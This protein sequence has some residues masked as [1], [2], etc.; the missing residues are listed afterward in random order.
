VARVRVLD[1][2][3]VN[4][5]AAGEVVERP[6]SVVKEL[7]DNALDAGARRIEIEVAGGGKRSIRLRDDG[8]GMGRDDALLALE[9]H[10]TSKLSR[11]ED[12]EKIATLGFRGEALPSIA[13]VS[14]FLLQTSTGAGPGTEI[15]VR[16]GRILG[17]RDVE[18][19]RGTTVEVA[20]LFF[21]TPA[22]RKFLKSDPTETG[23]VVRLVTRAALAR[24]DVA[25]RLLVDGRATISANPAADR[26]RR[27]EDLFGP[28]LAGDLLAVSHAS[29]ALAV[30]GFVVRPASAHAGRLNQHF[31]VNGR[32]VADRMLSHAVAEAFSNT[33]SRERQ[34]AVFLFLALDHADVDVNV[35][36]QKSE[37]RFRKQ[38]EVHDRLVEAVRRVLGAPAAVPAHH[39]LRPWVRQGL[40][41]RAWT[42]AAAAASMPAAAEGQARVSV[43]AAE[44]RTAFATAAP[45]SLFGGGAQTGAVADSPERPR[46][47][48][49]GQFD[50]SY[51]LASDH[52]G[53]LVVDQHAAHERILFEKYL[54]E[55]QTD[56]VE[57]QGLLFPRMIELSPH[58]ATLAGAESAELER[59]GFTLAPFGGSAFRLDG[60]PAVAAGVDPEV[61]L[62]KILGEAGRVR[63]VTAGVDELRLALV[64]SAACQAAIKIHH[65][66]T[67]EGMQ[68]LI[69]DLMQ[70]ENP[71]TCPHGRPILF[72]LT[73]E[74]IER[75]FRRR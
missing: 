39:E 6:A 15:E 22:R 27:I 70:A 40:P 10:A 61:L 25:F 9:R 18:L 57:T 58:E 72:R 21:N 74:E 4:R 69:D 30:E 24:P 55:A 5:I 68:R 56:R 73:L 53:V 29:G 32:G 3:L 31:F 48:V 42:P 17:V 43:A 33:T 63:S 14:R 49:V 71:T 65:R 20:G 1:D 26:L 64:T 45:A 11:P 50:D 34:P 13:S 44:P 7:L 19:S 67:T 75:T 62:R 23:H 52:T 37:V 12:L 46:A 47:T 35:H 16:G 36:P 51:I 28:D 2:V 38:G 59:L 8:E 60:I 66:L 54:G 41:A